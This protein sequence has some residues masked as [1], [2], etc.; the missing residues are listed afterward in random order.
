MK[1]YTAN[2]P[3][4]D[5]ITAISTPIG[6]GGIGIV[7]L[8]GP[9]SLGIAD[10]IFRP[11]RGKSL[12]ECASHTVRY[13]RIVDPDSCGTI[14]EVIVTVMRSPGSYTRED[15]VEIN[16]HGGLRSLKNVLDLAVKCGARIAEPGE[17]T[18]R[19][20]LNG[21]IDLA[22]AEAVIDVIRSRTDASLKMAMAQLSGDLS[23]EVDSVREEILDITAEIEAG[24]DFPEE[25]IDVSDMTEISSRI[26][27]VIKELERLSDTYKDGSIFKNGILAV[28]CGKP[29]VGKSSLMNLLLKRDRVIVSPMPGTTRDAV[30]ETIALK[31]I[32]I[33]LVDTAGI[34]DA[35]DEIEK[36][37]ISRS[38]KYLSE[39]DLV[40]FVMDGS[41]G[42]DDD[43]RKI[44]GLCEGKKVVAV[45][46]KTDLPR[47]VRAGDID[48]LF[49]VSDAVEISVGKRENIELL[50]ETI[51]KS[52]W[53]GGI[54][55][56]SSAVV[57]SSRHK[58]LLD[59]ALADMLSVKK[60]IGE[61][62]PGETLAIDLKE[63]V[64]ALGLITGKTVSDDILDRI[65]ERFC[66]GK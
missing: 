5:T 24:I 34:N 28:I 59:K 48:K 55:M 25:D 20:F 31:G 14:D 32:P 54:D 56:S 57:S 12:S 13:G 21:R 27:V 47:H 8:S 2:A 22:Q 11:A 3:E 53:N 33:R 62:R 58:E 61:S 60:G 64:T 4:E 18:K 30:E 15:V 19:A 26:D 38:K 23:R 36:E 9:A 40:I 16:C 42:I 41:S 51:V 1:K 17:F 63:S 10:M 29:N 43:D 39:A 50:E 65:F 7:R 37:G 44:F 66:I 46:N 52:V 6:E 35:K 49:S 45:I